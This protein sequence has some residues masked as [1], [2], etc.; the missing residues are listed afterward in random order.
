MSQAPT[1]LSSRLTCSVLLSL[2]TQML[3]L[4]GYDFFATS[5][6]PMQPQAAPP[7]YHHVVP[8][9]PG[10]PIIPTVPS[11]P[12]PGN[13][14][15][16]VR[17]GSAVKS[18]RAKSKGKSPRKGARKKTSQVAGAGGAYAAAASRE[19]RHYMSP[20]RGASAAQVLTKLG[21]AALPRKAADAVPGGLFEPIFQNRQM[22]QQQ[23]GESYEYGPRALVPLRSHFS[24]N[25]AGKSQG[26][27]SAKGKRGASGPGIKAQQRGKPLKRKQQGAAASPVRGRLAATDGAALRSSRLFQDQLR[28]DAPVEVPWQ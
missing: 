11:G 2:S 21:P 4:Y 9:A 14:A 5:S 13:L 3:D 26:S 18:R 22:Q 16:R 17:G 20:P 27:G 24:V 7:I 12:Q 15:P 8:C 1:W 23:E 25:A 28:S 6:A 19:P 10:P